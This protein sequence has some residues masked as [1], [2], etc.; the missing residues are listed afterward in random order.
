MK[1]KDPHVIVYSLPAD[2]LTT[3]QDISNYNIH[4][5]LRKYG[6]LITSPF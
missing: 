6:G 3:N 1:D 4:L 5:I 2:N